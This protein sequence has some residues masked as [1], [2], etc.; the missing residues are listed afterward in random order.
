M[1]LLLLIDK[2]NNWHYLENRDIKIFIHNESLPIFLLDEV[3]DLPT[4]EKEEKE[5]QEENDKNIE[6]EEKEQKE[7]KK[8]IEEKNN[9]N[10]E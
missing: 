3:N 7:E 2:N 5:E 9:I 1:N 6:R 8:E 4:E 10:D